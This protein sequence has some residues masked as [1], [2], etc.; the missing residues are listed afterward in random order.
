MVKG[1]AHAGYAVPGEVVQVIPDG[2]KMVFVSDDFQCMENLLW[3]TISMRVFLSVSYSIIN[4][5]QDKINY[6]FEL[7]YLNLELHPYLYE[8]K[9]CIIKKPI[10]VFT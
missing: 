8:D 6:N 5:Y 1:F 9:H 3:L 7:F 4:Y 10:S 2:M